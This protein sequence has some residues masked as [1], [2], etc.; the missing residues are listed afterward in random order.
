MYV[1]TKSGAERASGAFV[2]E[3]G[4]TQPKATAC[5]VGDQAAP[6]TILGHSA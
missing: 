2:A 1:S 5:L 3:L 6:L 4:A